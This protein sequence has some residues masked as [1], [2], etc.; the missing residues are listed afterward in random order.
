MPNVSADAT[1]MNG[2]ST[3]LAN[4]CHFFHANLV[5]TGHHDEAGVT[6]QFLTLVKITICVVT[7]VAKIMPPSAHNSTISPDANT[8]RWIQMIQHPREVT[9]CAVTLLNNRVQPE[10]SCHF[11]SHSRDTFPRVGT[12][13]K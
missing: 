11:D 10:T 1:P 8:V 5:S 6:K 7:S 9:D 13:Q 2:Q 12:S 4:V 3:N